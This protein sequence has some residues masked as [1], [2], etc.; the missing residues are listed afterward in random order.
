M[1]T[2]PTFR[3]A[4]AVGPKDGPTGVLLMATVF[5]LYPFLRKLYA[6]GGYQG[7]QFQAGLRRVMHQVHVE[8]RPKAGQTEI[9]K[10]SDV[11]KGFVALP[12]CWIVERT[13]GAVRATPG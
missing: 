5:G 11:A 2:R 12:N 10:R 9:V 3:T 7:P 13:R 6:D 8:V 1:C 4:T